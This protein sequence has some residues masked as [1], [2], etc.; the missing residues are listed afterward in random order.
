VD[1]S[2]NP[3]LASI[4]PMSFIVCWIFHRKERE[5][6]I[7]GILPGQIDAVVFCWRCDR[8]RGRAVRVLQPTAIPAR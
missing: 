1:L 4:N 5:V 2:F 3:V 6:L 7:P 8:M